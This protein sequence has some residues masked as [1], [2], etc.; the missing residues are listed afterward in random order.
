MFK[1]TFNAATLGRIVLKHERT[2]SCSCF[3]R[4]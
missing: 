4:M 1:L 3:C 2:I